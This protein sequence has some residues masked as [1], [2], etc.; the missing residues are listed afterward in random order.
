MD[1]NGAHLVYPCLMKPVNRPSKPRLTA[2]VLTAMT[3]RLFINTARRFAYPFAPALSRGLGVSLP[4]IT[5][6]IAA[7]QFTGFI[8]L[9]FAPL[10]DRW[11]YRIMMLAGLGLL[12]LGMFIGGAF[13]IYATVFMALFLSGL[14]KSIFDPALQAYIGQRV[15][16]S[17]RGLAMGIIEMSWAGSSLIGI[18]LVGFVIDRFGWQAPFFLI[19]GTGFLGMVM[20]GALISKDHDTIS[21]PSEK[22]HVYNTLPQLIR[23]RPA[24]GAIGYIFFISAA[25]DNLFV[26]YG[27]WLEESFRLGIVALGI[28]TT[29]IGVAELLGEI[30]TAALADRL[31]LRRLIS[32]GVGL[33]AISY[34]ALSAIGQ[35]LPLAL[36]SLF[37]VFLT[38]EF[39]IVTS[40]SLATELL[41]EARATMMAGYLAGAS[42]GRVFG[43][44]I[45]GPVWIMGGNRCHR[46]GIG[47]D[48]PFGANIV[49]VRP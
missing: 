31:G 9:F 29:V 30:F 41:P 37:V 8:G 18:P 10:G 17:R 6:I 34:L 40:L 46:L 42:V 20:L 19:A 35:T 7:N 45:G 43:A 22:L 27:A 3:A 36:T 38:F 39:S 49:M 12:A 15:S 47:P 5:S 48:H 21:T 33:C 11:G 14:G 1:V 26:I 25:N 24:L 16:F 23:R 32:V 2:I 28:A 4:A 44:F 13:P